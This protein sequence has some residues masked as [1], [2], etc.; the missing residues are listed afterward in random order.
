LA[1]FQ[2][3]YEAFKSEGVGLL[4]GSVDVLQNTLKMINDLNLS[5]PIAYGLNLQATISSIGGFYEPEKQFLQPSGFL[6]R[7]GGSVEVAV[8]SSGPVGRLSAENVLSLV[9]YYR[10]N[11]D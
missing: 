3:Q 11:R 9:R 5:F 1:D 2:R 10:Q 7:P 8:Y 4:A 6:I